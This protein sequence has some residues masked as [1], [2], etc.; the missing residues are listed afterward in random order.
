[1]TIEEKREALEKACETHNPLCYSNGQ[2]P[3]YGK[4]CDCDFDTATIPEVERYYDI[5][6]DSSKV[7]TADND[8]ISDMV[9]DILDGKP[10][11]NINHPSHYTQGNIECIDAM[12]SAFG[13]EA[14]KHFCICNAFKYVWR[15]E[16]KNGVEDLDKAIWYINKYKELSADGTTN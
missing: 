15:S 6:V 7:E 5:L 12:A 14:V 11:D 2:C 1:M 8:D 9:K 13:K 4:D 10:A 16:H 3:F